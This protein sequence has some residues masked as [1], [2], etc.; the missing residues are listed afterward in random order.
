MNR[1]LPVWPVLTLTLL[2]TPAFS[3]DDRWRLMS[4][5]GECAEMAAL[6]RKVPGASHVRTPR[7]FVELMRQRGHEVSVDE[8]P[9]LRGFALGVRVPDQGLDLMFA[10]PPYCSGD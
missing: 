6:E 5:H 1:Y 4:R 10:K 2:V 3:S 7:Q 8:F 9:E